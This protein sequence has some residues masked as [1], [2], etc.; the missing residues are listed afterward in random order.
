MAAGF[1]PGCLLLCISQE[2]YQWSDHFAY[3]YSLQ[4]I[5]SLEEG[6]LVKNVGIETPEHATIPN[7]SAVV[8]KM[9]S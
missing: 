9:S 8:K 6:R 3:E 1:V 4:D 2:M 5:V 7:C